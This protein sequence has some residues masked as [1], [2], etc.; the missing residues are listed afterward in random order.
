MHYAFMDPHGIFFILLKTKIIG[1][2]IQ[3]QYMITMLEH[4]R[5]IE[6]LRSKKFDSKINL[7]TMNQSDHY[8][9]LKYQTKV[10]TV[11]RQIAVSFHQ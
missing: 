1:F 5:L 11:Q 7:L 4:F 8:K 9:H 10:A 6:H 3:Y 2:R